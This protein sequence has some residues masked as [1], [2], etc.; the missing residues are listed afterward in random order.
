MS[1]VVTRQ[2]RSD[3]FHRMHK[4]NCS[5]SNSNKLKELTNLVQ[6]LTDTTQA[7]N[8]EIESLKL[9]IQQIEVDVRTQTFVSMSN[10]MKL[11]FDT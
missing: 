7:L 10:L 2:L 4:R 9:R 3:T 11:D 5:Q 1:V 6:N 8:L